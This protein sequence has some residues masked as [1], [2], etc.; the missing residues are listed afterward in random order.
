MTW[1]VFLLICGCGAAAGAQLDG[2][3]WREFPGASA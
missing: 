2:R 3:E 1:G